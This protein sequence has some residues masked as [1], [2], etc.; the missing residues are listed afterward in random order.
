MIRQPPRPSRSAALLACAA[1]LCLAAC[2]G[3]QRPQPRGAASVAGGVDPA[4]IAEAHD[5]ILEAQAYEKDKKSDAAIAAYKAALE[6]YREFPA[7]WNNLG[8]LLMDRQRY[9]EAAECFN[10]AADLAPQDP[11]PLYNLG[12]CWDR[13]GYLGEALQHYQRAVERDGQYLPALRGSIRAETILNR[14]SPA[15]LERL[16]AALQ[17]EQEPRWRSWME[18]QRLRIESAGTASTRYDDRPPDGPI[19][20]TPSGMPSP[21]FGD[22]REAQP[23]AGPR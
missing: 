19:P 14:T 4:R 20:L 18:L 9:L 15:T 22:N 10:A 12:L 7:A 2:N 16:R 5:L 13:A 23:F 6:K 11:R 17:L 8:A 1:G 21:Q 3:A